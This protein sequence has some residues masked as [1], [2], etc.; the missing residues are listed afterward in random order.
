[1]EEAKIQLIFSDINKLSDIKLRRVT[2]FCKERVNELLIAYKIQRLKQAPEILERKMRY[3]NPKFLNL[4]Q[5]MENNY[6]EMWI[7]S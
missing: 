3:K 5:L 1:M 2:N 7:L 4:K 6:E